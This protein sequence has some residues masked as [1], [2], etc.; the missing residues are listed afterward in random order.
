MA[1][2]EPDFG[3]LAA[4]PTWV[5]APE[6]VDAMV[7]E[8]A[9]FH[10]LVEGVPEPNNFWFLNGIP[11]TSKF[12]AIGHFLELEVLR[13]KGWNISLWTLILEQVPECL[14]V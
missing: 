8:T 6:S 3:I 11:I 5:K 13:V 1:V 7:G 4:A 12:V 2:S 9:V 14:P 10:C